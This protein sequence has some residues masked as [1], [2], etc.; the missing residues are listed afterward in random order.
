MELYVDTSSGEMELELGKLDDPD[1]T[2]TTDYDT[3]RKI[4]VDQ[5]AQA[6]MQAFMSG[7]VKVQGDIMK[8]MQMQ[9]MEPDATA[10]N[11]ADEI[12]ARLA[13][14]MLTSRAQVNRILDP[15]KGNVTIETLQ[16]AAQLL[17]RQ[18]RVELL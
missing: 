8:L 6:G 15:D 12:K 17:G 13:D 10:K 3:A 4:L 9:A 7:R 11:V 14:L 16:R 5:D 18:L 2:I 1:V